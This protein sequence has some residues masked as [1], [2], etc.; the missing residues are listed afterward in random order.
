MHLQD[1]RPA[2]TKQSTDNANNNGH[3]CTTSFKDSEWTRACLQLMCIRRLWTS[4]YTR[5]PV[6]QSKSPGRILFCIYVVPSI[7]RICNPLALVSISLLSRGILQQEVFL[8]LFFQVIQLRQRISDFYNVTQEF[9]GKAGKKTSLSN[10]LVLC[11]NHK[12][13]LSLGKVWYCPNFSPLNNANLL[14]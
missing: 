9:C 8:S 1:W 14:Y 12:I 4:N 7:H 3:V 6:A 10:F 2:L 13:I 11:L 5:E